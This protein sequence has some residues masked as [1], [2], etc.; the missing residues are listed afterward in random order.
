[1]RKA[2]TV[3]TRILITTTTI[4]TG[5]IRAITATTAVAGTVVHRVGP[6]RAAIVRPIRDRAARALRL[7]LDIGGNNYLW[8]AFGRPSLYIFFVYLLQSSF[9]FPFH[10]GRYW[11]LDLPNAANVLGDVHNGVTI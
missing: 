2:A 1:M 9:G 10:G 8:A 6:G 3:I 5:T 4:T 7:V 11:V